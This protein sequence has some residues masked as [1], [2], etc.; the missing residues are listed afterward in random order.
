MLVKKLCSSRITHQN[1]NL[2]IT[3]LQKVGKKDEVVILF[4]L[5]KYC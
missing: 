4:F 1:H 3:E 5:F 2:K